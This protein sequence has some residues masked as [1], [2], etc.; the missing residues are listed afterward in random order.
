M[1]LNQECWKGI[2]NLILNLFEPN[3]NSI[4]FCGRLPFGFTECLD[5]RDCSSNEYC[6]H[7]TE[8]VISP[9]MLHLG[10][11]KPDHEHKLWQDLLLFL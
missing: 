1:F 3:F 9:K 8:L 10:Y 7:E 5:N 11:C 6:Y 2:S 4:R